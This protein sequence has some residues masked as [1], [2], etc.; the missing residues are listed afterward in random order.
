MAKSN[1]STGFAGFLI[2]VMVGLGIAA[3]AAVLIYNSPRPF[4]EK[5]QKVT[6]DVDPAEKLAGSVDPNRRLNSSADAEAVAGLD[7][8]VK[9]VNVADA[10]S[11]PARD[12]SGK[13][14]DP[15][16]VT[17]V[18]Y[19]LQTGAYRNRQAA[20]NQRAELAMNL[21]SA[22]I[23]HSKDLWL[24]RVG[25]YETNQ[26]A[27]EIQTQLNNANIRSTVVTHR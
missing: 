7:T 22:T 3:A 25:P 18:T 23:V 9:T 14:I 11:E 6:A 12:K 4:M 19:W 15:G 26:M 10:S 8:A 1:F 17:P 21:F 5:V 20:E 13:A 24:V 27:K 2:G 16:K